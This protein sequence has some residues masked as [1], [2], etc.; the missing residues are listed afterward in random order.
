MLGVTNGYSFALFVP[1]LYELWSIC[2]VNCL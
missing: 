1:R 2:T